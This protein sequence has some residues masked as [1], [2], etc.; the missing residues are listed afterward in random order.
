LK[1]SV[2]AQDIPA[3]R[4]ADHLETEHGVTDDPTAVLIQHLTG[5]RATGGDEAGERPSAGRAGDAGEDA[6]VDEDVDEL[7][8][9]EPSDA[10]AF[11]QFLAA[12]PPRPAESDEEAAPED[13]FE[14]MLST[15]P[16]ADAVK[17]AQSRAVRR[18]A[19]R[20][21]AAEAAEARRAEA[22]DAADAEDAEAPTE[23]AP[24]A[25]EAA[26]GDDFEKMLATYPEVDLA[27]KGPPT[28]VAEGEPDRDART[29][30]VWDEARGVTEDD[31]VILPPAA[32]DRQRARQRRL[33]A[34]LGIAAAVILIGVAVI[35]LLTRDTG[36]S[37][38]TAA[39]TPVPTTATTVAP[40]F[41]PGA[42]GGEPT[43]VPA[44]TP[45]TV[46]TTTPPTTAAPAPAPAP[47]PAT[48]AAP[49]PDPAANIAF[50]QM[51]A[52]CSGGQLS[53]AGNVV[54]NNANT[55][56]FSFTIQFVNPAGAVVGTASGSVAH[57]PPHSR[58]P[59]RAGGTCSNI[60]DARPQAQI[61]SITTG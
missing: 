16:E 53:V 61:T 18:E 25:E 29:F 44:T 7:P 34:L 32:G 24:L 52:V 36:K 39:T 12:H 42:Q 28:P 41:L 20:R 33:A 22:E 4:Y 50:P 21:A 54:N 10:D 49:A 17:L 38:N 37:K 27:R 45:A 30:A 60:T 1:C 3:D 15:H 6:D 57:E 48:T 31:T 40:T 9:D 23:E 35:Y 55:Y 14:E 56:S 11:E 43:T 8:E 58:G 51:N 5:L 46:A 47:A 2:C 26:P 19:D 59:F 13:D